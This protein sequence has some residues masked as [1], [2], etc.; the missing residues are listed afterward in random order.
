MLF[1]QCE[2]ERSHAVIFYGRHLR[3]DVLKP[4]RRPMGQVWIFAADESPAHYDVDGEDW[5]DD[6][7][8]HRF[9]WTMTYDKTNTDIHLP[10]GKLQKRTHPN[11]RNYS[12]IAL[13]K[14]LGG[15]LISSHCNNIAQR[16]KYAK[17]LQRYIPIDIY[18]KCGNPW[19]CGTQY[20]HD[21]CFDILNDTY[22]FFLAFENSLCRGYFTE[23]L[24]E[25]YK[26]DTLIVTRGGDQGE[27]A[28]TFPPGT[29]ISTDSF[30]SVDELGEYLAALHV[31]PEL[32]AERLK[33][34]DK[35][36]SESYS[37]VYQDAMCRLCRMMNKQ[38]HFR[39]QIPDT[40]EWAYSSKPSLK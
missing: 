23:K 32:Y 3:Q 30:Q 25:N 10:Y 34:K 24:F 6:N 22:R 16:E 37:S 39:K 38:D 8:R 35:Y 28:V 17:I 4:I 20:V 5:S 14:T 11:T 2:L 29:V 18:G 9:N 36:Y 19:E 31:S 7:W 27:A 40:F 33:D 26:Y 1:D 15:I 21:K 12:A 13:Q